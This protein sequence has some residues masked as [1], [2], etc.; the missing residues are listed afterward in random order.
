MTPVAIIILLVLCTSPALAQ[1]HP[2]R[3]L[4]IEFG[5]K[6]NEPNSWD[7]SLSIDKGEIVEL[8]GPPVQ[9]RRVNRTEQLLDSAHRPLGSL[10][11]RHASS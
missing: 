1:E 5:I 11:R 8:R 4:N 9:R 10:H 2:L 3:A 6:D 7:G